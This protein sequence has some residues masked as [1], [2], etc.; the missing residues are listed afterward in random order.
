MRPLFASLAVLGAL[1]GA[2]LGVTLYNTRPP[3]AVP[4]VIVHV[5]ATPAPAV[6]VSVP[7]EPVVATPPPA[8]APLD[9]PRALAPRIWA[10]CI[11]TPFDV[12]AP[13]E[14]GWDS[15]F[16]AISRD[17]RT[18]VL[19]HNPDD[20]GSRGNPGL[21]LSFLD[22]TSGKTTRTIEILDPDDYV[23]D[24][25]ALATTLATRV[26]RAQKQL[27]EAGYRALARL[28][29]YNEFKSAADADD[30]GTP[31]TVT[32]ETIYAEIE[33][34]GA[35][36]IID[37]STRSVIFQHAFGVRNPRPDTDPAEDDCAGWSL[38]DLTLYW[39]AETRVV[40]ANQI[41][42]TGGCMCGDETVQ[43]IA[44]AK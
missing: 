30:D 41:Y 16:P 37:P 13:A 19:A 20:N 3:A 34:T 33:E 17:G 14:C 11:V 40:L 9:P 15:G 24:D 28:G 29:D 26:A 36:R 23:E 44:R 12:P 10:Q 22:T 4:E 18:I 43:Q 38:H 21:V 31:D 8:A 39:D 1:G 42:R 27:D 35:T 6:H 32:H 2:T 7:A 5:P 25:P